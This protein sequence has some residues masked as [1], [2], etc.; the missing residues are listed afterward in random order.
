MARFDENLAKARRH[1]KFC[2]SLYRHQIDK[3]RY[4]LHE[5]PATALS[6]REEQIEALCKLPM[7]YVVDASGN[8]LS[9]G[10]PTG[11]RLGPE[12]EAQIV[13]LVD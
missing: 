2:C 10:A 1:V 12:L 13:P 3:H 6:W 5:H 4:F 7:T 8:I 9:I 11:D